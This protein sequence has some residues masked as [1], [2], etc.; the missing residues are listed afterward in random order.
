M[1]KKYILKY[2]L[3]LIFLVIFILSNFSKYKLFFEIFLKK[4]YLQNN[5]NK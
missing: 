2:Y 3:L 1:K 4:Y 5:S